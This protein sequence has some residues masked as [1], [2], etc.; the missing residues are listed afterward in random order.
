MIGG[1]ARG[2]AGAKVASISV[3]AETMAKMI[4]PGAAS[5][6]RAAISRTKGRQPSGEPNSRPI[7]KCTLSKPAA[8]PVTPGGHAPAAPASAPRGRDC[9][10]GTRNCS[11][12]RTYRADS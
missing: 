9:Q 5:G 2:A 1:L 11:D 6:Q 12:L 10:S 8:P 7:A 4:S 3:A